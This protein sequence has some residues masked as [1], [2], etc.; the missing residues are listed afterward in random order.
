MN[1]IEYH[2]RISDIELKKESLEDEK[3]ILNRSIS[4]NDGDFWILD[5]KMYKYID[6]GNPSIFEG[7]Y[8]FFPVYEDGKIIPLCT[9]R[10]HFISEPSAFKAT[11]EE[12]NEYFKK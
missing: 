6:D 4:I 7:R 1:R 2:K 5:N 11:E 9:M 10:M 3:K 12:I 8:G